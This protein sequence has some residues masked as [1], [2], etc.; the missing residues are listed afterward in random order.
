MVV[1]FS[2]IGAGESVEVGFDVDVV[3][4][5]QPGLAL[6]SNQAEVAAPGRVVVTD[7]PGTQRIQ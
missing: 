3:P 5:L 4:D 2:S 1:S 6:I 7:D